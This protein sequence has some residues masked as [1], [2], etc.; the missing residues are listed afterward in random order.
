VSSWTRWEWL[1]DVLVVLKESVGGW[2]RSSEKL[3]RKDEWD[4]KGGLGRRNCILLSGL[5]AESKQ[6]PGKMLMPVSSGSTGAK[7]IFE[8][9]VKAFQYAI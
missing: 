2:G 7:G 1:V 4:M 8:A 6:D 9:A 5:G 3:G